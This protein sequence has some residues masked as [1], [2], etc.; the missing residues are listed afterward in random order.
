MRY[1][2]AALFILLFLCIAITAEAQ[3]FPP[4]ALFRVI[5]TER[6]DIIYPRE[7]EPSARLLATYA[8]SVY[9]EISTLLGIE[10]PGRIPVT[11]APHT[12]M[13]NG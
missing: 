11:F 3:R 13:F 1:K 7:S 5:K 2:F 9:E 12:E 10:V 6:F 4:F 8:D